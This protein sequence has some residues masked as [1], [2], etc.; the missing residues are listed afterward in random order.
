MEDVV[1]AVCL[2]ALLWLTFS[3]A[4]SFLGGPIAV[5]RRSGLLRLGRRV[6]RLLGN[7][8][9]TGIRW[10]VRRRRRRV[11]R[12]LFGGSVGGIR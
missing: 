5:L 2:M 12:D 4:L 1:R 8:A 11:R 7:G 3:T 9:L 6:L 10:L